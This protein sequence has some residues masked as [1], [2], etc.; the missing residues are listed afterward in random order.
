VF[1]SHCHLNFKDFR[2]DGFKIA[3]QCLRENIQLMVVGSQ[4]DTSKDAVEFANHFGSGVYASIGLHPTHT[5]PVNTEQ[6]WRSR[7]EIFNQTKYRDLIGIKSN[8]KNQKLIPSS[9]EVSKRQIKNIKKKEKSN[10]QYSILNSKVKAIGE[11]GLDYYTLNNLSEEDMRKAKELQVQN[12][13]AHID[14]AFENNLPMIIHIRTRKPDESAYSDAAEI[15]NKNYSK[16]SKISGVIHCYESNWEQARKFLDLGL[17]IGFTGLITYIDSKKLSGG[18]RKK[19]ES[20]ID[21]IKKMPQDRILSETDSPYLLPEPL[22]SASVEQ[23]N[24]PLNIK[25]VVQKI[26]QTRGISFEDAAKITEENA[27]SLFKI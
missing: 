2:K 5:F 10:I 11:T 22:K 4:Y 16:I 17:Y 18:Q 7:Q 15:L 23:I 20:I 27:R 6:G 13:I 26:A 24:T 8:I 1:D 3:E 19:Y 12:F 9:F 14:F 21:V 25:C